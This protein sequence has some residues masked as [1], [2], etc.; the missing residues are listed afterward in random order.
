MENK[1]CRLR[2]RLAAGKAG[3]QVHQTAGFFCMRIS[4][5]TACFLSLF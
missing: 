1:A 3:G 4:F 5:Q 2:E